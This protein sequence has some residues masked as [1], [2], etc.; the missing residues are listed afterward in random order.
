V[1]D[2]DRPAY[3]IWGEN[4]RFARQLSDKASAGEIYISAETR[5]QLDPTF[6]CEERHLMHRAGG[7]PWLAFQLS[8]DTS[9]LSR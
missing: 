6:R 4:F 5:S 7:D 2:S 8:T 3:G 1:F 9:S